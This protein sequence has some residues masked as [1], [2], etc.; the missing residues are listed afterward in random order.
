GL[1]PRATVAFSASTL[2]CADVVLRNHSPPL[3]GGPSSVSGD[4]VSLAGTYKERA[5]RNERDRPISPCRQPDASAARRR[6]GRG[7]DN[8]PRQPD[9][10]EDGVRKGRLARALHAP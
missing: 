1:G 8:A 4:Q 10:Q 9:A 3:D 7:T 2:P 5:K 6:G